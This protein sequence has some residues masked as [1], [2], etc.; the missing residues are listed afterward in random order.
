MVSGQF[1]Q[2]NKGKIPGSLAENPRLWGAGRY[3]GRRS[4]SFDPSESG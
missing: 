4:C 2:A 3:P 1:V